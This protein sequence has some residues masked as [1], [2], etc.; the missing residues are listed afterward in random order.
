MS[1]AGG[2]NKSLSICYRLPRLGGV[3]PTF[4]AASFV[5]ERPLQQSSW[6][7]RFGLQWLD[8]PMFNLIWCPRPSLPSPQ[9]LPIWVEHLYSADHL[10]KHE[11]QPPWPPPARRLRLYFLRARDNASAV[12]FVLWKE[13]VSLSSQEEDAPADAP[14][15]GWNRAELD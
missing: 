5:N 9:L 3:W 14:R 2:L 10:H 1:T 13:K 15:G 6:V 8:A 7:E 12:I 4:S 11:H